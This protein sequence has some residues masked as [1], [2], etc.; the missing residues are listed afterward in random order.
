MN[1]YENVEIFEDTKR[2]CEKNEKLKTSIAE[3]VKNQKL[4]LESE[5]LPVVDKMCFSHEAKVVVSTKRTFEA[6]SGYVGQ[7]VAVH[8][9]A[10]PY[11]PGGGVLRGAGAQE[12]CL[13]R[14]S[15][16]YF[17]LSVPELEK[18]FYGP[19]R[20]AKNQIGTAD[21]IYTPAVTVFKTDTAKPQLMDEA[22]WYDVDVITCAAPDLRVKKNFHD[23]RNNVTPT[24]KIT[25]KELLEIHKKRLSRILDVAAL[26]GT[27]VVILG[28]FGCGA[29]QNKPEVVARAAKEVIADYLYAFETVEFAVYCP[30]QND[31]NF[32]VFKRVLG[33]LEK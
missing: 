20:K 11:K 25:D 13:C 22:A 29:Y 19:H 16:L 6:A 10:S 7:K 18:G 32:K 33:V 4:I 21:I 2:L 28:A 26:N 31:M 30:P 24:V 27:E 5:K 8:N 14:C 9:F 1:T 12:E 3:S 23:I 15:G 17:C